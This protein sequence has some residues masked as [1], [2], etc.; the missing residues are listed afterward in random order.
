M[1]QPENNWQIG[2][3]MLLLTVIT[4]NISGLNYSIKTHRMGK[5]NDSLPTTD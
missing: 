3:F 2:N 4:W 1:Q 5:S